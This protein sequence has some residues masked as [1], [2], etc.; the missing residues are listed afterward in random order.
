MS[1][2]RSKEPRY[3]VELVLGGKRTGMCLPRNTGNWFTYRIFDGGEEIGTVEV[4]RGSIFWRPYRHKRAGMSYRRSWRRFA[5][6]MEH[7]SDA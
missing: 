1:K 3:G 5:E 7:R 2:R 6:L 4:G